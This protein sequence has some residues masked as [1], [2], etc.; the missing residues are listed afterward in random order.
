MQVKNQPGSNRDKR[1]RVS[2]APE[3]RE[4][5]FTIS[6]KKIVYKDSDDGHEKRKGFFVRNILPTQKFTDY[7]SVRKRAN[8]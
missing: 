2:E 7:N 6:S 4:D 1:K 8:K 5:L 3:K